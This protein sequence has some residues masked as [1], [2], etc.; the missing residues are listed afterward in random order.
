MSKP[1]YESKWWGY[2]YDQMMAEQQDVVDA[3]LRFYQANLQQVTGPVLECACGTGLILLPLLARGH[4]M[5][6]FD[7]SSSMLATLTGKLPSRGSTTSRPASLSR[8]LN[9]SADD[10]RFAAIL[11]PTNTFSMLPTQEA[12]IRTLRTIHAH[13]APTGK[14]LLDL[15]LAGVRDVEGQAT[16]GRWHIWTHPETGRPIRQRVDG[17]IDFTNQRILD[18]CFIEYDHESVEFPMT[19]RWIL[20]G[21]VCAAAAP[22]RLR[23][24]GV[25]QYARGRPARPRA[26]EPAKLLDYRERLNGAHDRFPDVISAAF[27]L[28]PPVVRPP[29]TALELPPLLVER[30]IGPILKAGFGPTAFP[31]YRWRRR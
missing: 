7:I 26:G 12:Q 27:R 3:N 1:N 22:G 29:N 4:D 14:L 10:Q 2:I 5:Y 25:F 18:R 11:I 15:R 20:Q 9:C 30:E 17:Q 23:E 13:L 8:N 28:Q 21:R 6:G 31:F 19:A 16:E 24:L